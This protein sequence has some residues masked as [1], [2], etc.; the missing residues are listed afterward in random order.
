[1]D[2]NL[3]VITEA[4]TVEDIVFADGVW[5]CIAEDGFYQSDFM[6][7]VENDCWVGVYVDSQIIGA[8][9]FHLLNSATAQLHIH[10][11]PEYRDD[12][13]NEC[14]PFMWRWFLENKRKECVKI[15][16]SIPACWPNV[17]HFSKNNGMKDE[18]IN[19]KSY[20]KNGKLYDQWM[21]GATIKDIEEWLNV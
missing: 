2:I 14:I 9:N 13:A 3:E 7:D 8:F 20:W 10:I 15:V 18:G 6:A 5:Q 11:L 1:M 19:R 16:A 17:Y 21:L 12:Y 4:Q